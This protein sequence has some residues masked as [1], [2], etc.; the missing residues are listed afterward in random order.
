MLLA[1]VASIFSL[2]AFLGA[3]VLEVQAFVLASPDSTDTVRASVGSVIGAVSTRSAVAVSVGPSVV[4]ATS[5]AEAASIVGASL[6]TTLVSTTPVGWFV[7]S[8]LF[9]AAAFEL[10]LI[11]LELGERQGVVVA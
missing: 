4:G 11:Q 2:E 10:W 1:D 7:G 3:S 8:P 9:F 5:V 6:E